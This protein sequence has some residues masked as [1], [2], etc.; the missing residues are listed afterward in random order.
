MI[1]SECMHALVVREFHL[2]GSVLL[3]PA[4]DMWTFGID[5]CTYTCVDMKRDVHLLI[6]LEM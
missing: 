1:R 5:L 2:H 3:V 6:C 4:Y